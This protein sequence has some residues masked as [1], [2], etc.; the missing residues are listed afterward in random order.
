[1]AYHIT[2]LLIIMINILE[3]FHIAAKEI[4]NLEYVEVKWH[5]AF[6]WLLVKSQNLSHL[7]NPAL[8]DSSSR[9][10]FFISPKQAASK[11]ES[12]LH[13]ICRTKKIV[14]IFPLFI[15]IRTGWVVQNNISTLEILLNTF[16]FKC[17]PKMDQV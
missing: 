10:A 11:R 4:K 2:C 1:M 5:R 9:T 17:L 7:K 13:V 6:I 15:T 14:I 16:I 3:C 12:K 8:H